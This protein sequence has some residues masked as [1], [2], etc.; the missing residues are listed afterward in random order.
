MMR[1]HA[2]RVGLAVLLVIPAV[3]PAF[4]SDAPSLAARAA[5]FSAV[6]TATADLT[7]ER[8]VSLVDEVLRADGTIALAA[9]A[10]F[11]LDL[12]AP[13]PMTLIAAGQAIAV[14][15]ARGKTLPLPPEVAGLAAFAH[16]LTDLLLGAHAPQGFREAWRDADTVVLTPAAETASP[17]SEIA[18][19]FPA[20]GPIPE[21]ITLRERGG[22]RTVIRL[23]H[24]AL[25]PA[26]DAARFAP[27]AAPK[28]STP[29]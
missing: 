7:Q 12:T 5:R 27:S 11:R 17:F 24:I 15:D 14:V 8:E 21:E 1:T 10:S 19:R 22:D 25:N 28:G 29:P 16:T 18:L 13:E 26:L 3:P 6:R 23:H 20:S 9:P 4:A 2:F